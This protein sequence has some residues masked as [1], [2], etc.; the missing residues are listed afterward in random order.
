MLTIRWRHVSEILFIF[1]LI[2]TDKILTMTHI[3]SSTTFTERQTSDYNGEPHFT[4]ECIYDG[5]R[6]I[7][8]ENFVFLFLFLFSRH[9]L[10][11]FE[12][13]YV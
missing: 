8:Q 13:W 6:S 7:I 9:M 11:T 3:S 4:S 5:Y 1:F 10:K 12:I 2:S